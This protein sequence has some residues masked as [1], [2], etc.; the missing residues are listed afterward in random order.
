MF[1]QRYYRFLLS[2][3]AALKCVA[4]QQVRGKSGGCSSCSVQRG[5]SLAADARQ[6]LALKCQTHSRS[7]V[8]SWVLEREC[9]KVRFGDGSASQMPYVWLRDNCQCP[10]CYNAVALGR[11]FLL[12]DLDIEVH[13]I[14]VQDSDGGVKINWSDGHRSEYTGE[15][16][17][18]RAFTP[19]ARARQRTRY[20]FKREPW[21]ADHQLVEF[22]YHTLLRDD[23]TLLA[24]LLTMEQKGSAMVR[25]TPDS[26]VAG[27]RL[28]EHIA[29][30]KQSHYGPHSPVINRANSNNVAFTNSKLGL[31]NDLA[32][33]E[34][35]PGIIFIQCVKQE[36]GAG[37]A[38]VVSDGLFAAECLRRRHP[39]AFQVLATTDAYF[40]DKGH[41][42]FSW[43]MDRFFKISKRPIITVNND[44]EVVCVAMNNG[45]RASH[46]DLSAHLVKKFYAAMKLFNDI[47][48]DNAI[49][50]KMEEGE[51][52][53]L[54]NVRCVHGREAYDAQSERHIESSYLDWDEA[55]CRRRRLQEDLGVFL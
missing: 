33:Y 52:M 1:S 6:Q 54:D 9:L 19:A 28:I 40:W 43:E 37:G 36:P 25:N 46:L 42:N 3:A 10:E 51:M 31:H 45:V 7:S 14:E 39:E 48:Y 4:R 41:A 15:W 16:L 23:Q 18:D 2:T 24:W 49:T 8:V 34:H 5:L 44:Q 50:F 26:D 27:P 12:D 53:T 38:S 55:R 21:G 13:P 47:L 22:D 17:Q 35:M 32:Q 30:V 11:N 29:F 20:A